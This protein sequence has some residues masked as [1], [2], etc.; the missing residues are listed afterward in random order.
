MNTLQAGQPINFPSSQPPVF[1]YWLI[2]PSKPRNASIRSGTRARPSMFT[3][4]ITMR[5][6]MR[7]AAVTI[8]GHGRPRRSFPVSRTES[9]F[10]RPTMPSNSPPWI[11]AI[12][13]YTFLSK[14][15]PKYARMEPAPIA[16]ENVVVPF[17]FAGA[18]VEAPP[19]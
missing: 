9:R 17:P 19:G 14:S 12:A 11:E 7:P 18:A 3:I 8:S 10:T 13:M 16:P 1:M 6:S 2:V 15:G 5:R 4:G